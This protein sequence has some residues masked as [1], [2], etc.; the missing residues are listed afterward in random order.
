MGTPPKPTPSETP[1]HVEQ[2]NNKVGEL[3]KSVQPHEMTDILSHPSSLLRK[4]AADNQNQNQGGRRS[5]E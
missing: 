2:F 1:S 4:A 5:S 3:L